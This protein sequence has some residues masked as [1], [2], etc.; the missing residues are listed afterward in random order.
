MVER[1][2]VDSRPSAYEALI[3]VPQA[4]SAGLVALRTGRRLSSVSPGLARL[5]TNTTGSDHLY[6]R[7]RGGVSDSLPNHSPNYIRA[8]KAVIPRLQTTV[9]APVPLAVLPSPGWL[10]L[11]YIS[12]PPFYCFFVSLFPWTHPRPLLYHRAPTRLS[13]HRLHQ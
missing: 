2:A 8:L 7:S 12:Q 3:A 4:A 5:A 11:T 6:G 9:P 10:F 1:N 13:L